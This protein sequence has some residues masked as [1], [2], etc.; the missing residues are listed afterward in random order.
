[1]HF[2]KIINI[3]MW[4]FLISVLIICFFRY[5]IKK[6]GS[7]LAS[8]TPR[9]IFPCFPISSLICNLCSLDI[10]QPSLSPSLPS[11]HLLLPKAYTGNLQCPPLNLDYENHNL[12]LSI[13]TV[14]FQKLHYSWPHHIPLKVIK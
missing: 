1:M 11:R 6:Q 9:I 2:F 12:I 4:L 7:H 5:Q 8:L 14:L 13:P 10:M 3:Q